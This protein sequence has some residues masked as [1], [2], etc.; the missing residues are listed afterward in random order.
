M[1]TADSPFLI[2][3]EAD[4]MDAGSYMCEVCLLVRACVHV[5]A[6]VRVRV[7]VYAWCAC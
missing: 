4:V 5:C 3:A 1:A 7:C 6:C 2:I